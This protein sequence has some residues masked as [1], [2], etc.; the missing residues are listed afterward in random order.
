M[1][2]FV[3]VVLAIIMVGLV[4]L[5]CINIS[6]KSMA[7]KTVSNAVVANETTDQIQQ[8]ITEN[9]PN[10]T[11]DQIQQIQEV[12]STSS[13]INSFTDDLLN[14]ITEATLNGE[15]VDTASI[16]NQLSQVF[17]DNV[18][19]IEQVIDQDI[20]DEQ[21]QIVQERLTDQ[22]GAL[23]TKI[24]EVVDSV[25]NGS[26]STTEFLQTYQTV[27]SMAVRV[28]CIIGIIVCI[29]LIG[30]LNRSLY[31]W[32]I[33]A[34]VVA[35]VSAIIIGL[36]APLVVNA[37]E[38]TIGLRVLNMSI[39]IPVSMLRV[40]G[41]VLGVIGIILIVAYIILSRKFPKYERSYY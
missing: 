8:V 6:I 34:G 14:Q 30:L 33:Y 29:V 24:N 13:S 18:D 28:G 31:G 5:L 1:K 35:I 40:E 7:A 11:D 20:T 17:V 27:S 4:V 12:I 38:F 10:V 36:F 3:S 15:Q 19:Q 25:Q 9:F 41:I 37:I 39:D 16:M 32:S 2:K 21:I 22:N 26:T 23:Q